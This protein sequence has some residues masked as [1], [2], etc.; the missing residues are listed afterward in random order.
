MINKI[1]VKDIID[2]FINNIYKLHKFFYSI[3]FNYNS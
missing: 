3:I 1:I 2:L